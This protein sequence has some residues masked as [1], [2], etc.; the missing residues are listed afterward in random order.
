MSPRLLGLLWAAEALRSW[1]RTARTFY[2]PATLH[3]VLRDNMG[4]MV[5]AIN[6]LAAC[7]AEVSTPSVTAAK[8]VEASHAG[9]PISKARDDVTRK[10]IRR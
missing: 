6:I 4:H 5:A 8:S 9:I 3:L 1:Y 10:V 7:V 2:Q